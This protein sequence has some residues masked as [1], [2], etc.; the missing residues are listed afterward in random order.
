M[1][2]EKTVENK[3]EDGI[4]R[5]QDGA[6]NLFNK[7]AD[8]PVVAVSVAGLFGFILGALLARKS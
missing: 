1:S 6:E 3:L 2:D 8:Q 4:G 5:V 7:A